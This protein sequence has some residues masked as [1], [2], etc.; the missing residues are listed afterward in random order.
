MMQKH[1][2]SSAAA[3]SAVPSSPS[4]STS[5]LEGAVADQH[6]GTEIRTRQLRPERG[7][8]REAHGGVVGG[9]EEFCPV[10]DEQIGGAEER[11]PHVGDN[12]RIV[13]EEGV[14]PLEEAGDGDGFR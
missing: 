13:L 2:F 7:G 5:H 9:A 12:D 14:Q 11:I 4:V 1:S 3:V 10:V 6:E 8:D